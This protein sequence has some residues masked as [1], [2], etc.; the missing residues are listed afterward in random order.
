[1][2]RQRGNRG[3]VLISSCLILSMVFVYS[4]IMTMR[5][6]TEHHAASHLRE[7]LQA[8][9]LAQGSLEQLREDLY[10]FLTE[11]GGPQG[12]ILLEKSR[13]S[14]SG[15]PNFSEKTLS[16]PPCLILTCNFRS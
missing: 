11:E 6:L 5:M 7:Q 1:M 9:D 14:G 3:F 2:G 13:I 15:T 12:L 8:L 16:S 10:A 4:N